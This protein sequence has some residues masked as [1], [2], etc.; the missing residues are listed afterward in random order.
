VTHRVLTGD[1][2]SWVGRWEPSQLPVGQR[3]QQ[4]VQLVDKLD[5]SVIEEELTRLHKEPTPMGS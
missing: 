3:L 4:P 5:E 2:R 1:Y